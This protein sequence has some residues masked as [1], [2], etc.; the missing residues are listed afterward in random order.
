MNPVTGDNCP[1]CYLPSQPKE[2]LCRRC[3]HFAHVNQLH[4]EC[5]ACMLSRPKIELHRFAIPFGYE[6]A[7]DA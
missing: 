2:R 1:W 7:S 4:C 6:G 3:G 5:A